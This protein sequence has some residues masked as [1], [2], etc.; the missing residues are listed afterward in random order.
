MLIQNNFANKNETD[1]LKNLIEEIS[2]SLGGM[3]SHERIVQVVS[4][5]STQYRDA[6]VTS[7]VPIFIQRYADET[8]RREI[9]HNGAR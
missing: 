1:S 7:F 9:Q 2:E 4:E 6:T 3:I 5:I 8:L